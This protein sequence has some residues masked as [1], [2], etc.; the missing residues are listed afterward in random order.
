MRSLALT[1]VDCLLLAQSICTKVEAANIVNLTQ[2]QWEVTGFDSV[3]WNGSDLI[4]ETQ[5]PNS[6]DFDIAGYFDWYSNGTY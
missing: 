3:N 4:F 2:G 1:A 5:I 6:S